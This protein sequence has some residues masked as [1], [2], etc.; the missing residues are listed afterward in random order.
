MVSRV[1]FKKVRIVKITNLEIVKQ[2]SVWNLEAIDE[3]SMQPGQKHNTYNNIALNKYGNNKI[4]VLRNE[5]TQ[6]WFKKKQTKNHAIL[7]LLS[8]QNSKSLCAL[9]IILA[10]TRP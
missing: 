8:I 2:L 5:W 3:H 10:V 4:A 9:Y 1:V 6:L 7:H